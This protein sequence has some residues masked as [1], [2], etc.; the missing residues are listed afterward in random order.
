MEAGIVKARKDRWN[1]AVLVVTLL[2]LLFYSRDMVLPSWLNI[3]LDGIRFLLSVMVGYLFWYAGVSTQ[4]EVK[5]LSNVKNDLINEIKS[6]SSGS[7]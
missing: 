2:V 3:L 5:A 4:C 6:C 1:A 7:R